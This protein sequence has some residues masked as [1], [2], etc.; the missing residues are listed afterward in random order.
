MRVVAV[1]GGSALLARGRAPTV[2]NR[3]AGVRAAARA[4][5]PLAL[6]HELVVIGH[7]SGPAAAELPHDLLE[8]ATPGPTGHL[9]QQD[10][11]NELPAGARVATI[12][13]LVEVGD[14][15][16]AGQAMPK[17]VLG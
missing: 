13:T 8:A 10:L 4:L 16:A 15:G 3:R 6:R 5:A 1:I 17:R 12:L 9:L 14:D 11:G 7:G 2:E